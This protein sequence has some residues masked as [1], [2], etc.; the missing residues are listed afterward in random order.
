MA[1]T[2]PI[3]I[4]DEEKKC[5]TDGGEWSQQAMACFNPSA[6]PVEATSSGSSCPTT[7]AY[8]VNNYCDKVKHLCHEHSVWAVN[9]AKTCCEQRKIGSNPE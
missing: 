2:P 6:A 8:T 5:I 1:R 4:S 9:C 3:G 7:D